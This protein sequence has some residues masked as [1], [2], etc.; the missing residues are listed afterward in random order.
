MKS[1]KKKYLIKKIKKYDYLFIDKNIS[2]LNTLSS[3]EL[4][5]LLR[6]IENSKEILE[7]FYIETRN[8]YVVSF[9]S[10]ESIYKNYDKDSFLMN[11]KSVIGN[12]NKCRRN[13]FYYFLDGNTSINNDVYTN[14]LKVSPE[15][16]NS[17]LKSIN[18]QELVIKDYS[19]T[20]TSC[21]FQVRSNSYILDILQYFEGSVYFKDDWTKEI[22][23]LEEKVLGIKDSKYE[24]TSWKSSIA[25]LYK[26]ED[27]EEAILFGDDPGSRRNVTEEIIQSLSYE[28]ER[29]DLWADDKFWKSL[30]IY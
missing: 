23:S 20:N 12:E 13:L 19:N 21:W 4:E 1:L 11:I 6:I 5:N 25:Y 8:V 29:D 14:L 26:L 9:T 10:Y 3:I 28:R 18:K 2:F 27:M 22:R 16:S 30:E 15:F 24:I 17:Y 7:N